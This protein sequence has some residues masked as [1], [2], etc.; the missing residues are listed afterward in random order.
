MRGEH[1]LG[2]DQH[3]CQSCGVRP[4][5]GVARLVTPKDAPL[6]TSIDITVCE[7]CEPTFAY[8]FDD[9][10]ALTHLLSCNRTSAN[11]HPYLFAQLRSVAAPLEPLPGLPQEALDLITLL[12][13]ARDRVPIKTVHR[14]LGHVPRSR[15]RHALD[16]I[17]HHGYGTLGLGGSALLR[18]DYYGRPPLLD[19][20]TPIP[21][22]P[23]LLQTL[24][25]GGELHENVAAHLLATLAR[26][27]GQ[28][29]SRRQFKKQ[30]LLPV[31]PAEMFDS[32]VLF[33]KRL[34]INTGVA[35]H[36][37]DGN[38]RLSRDPLAYTSLQTY[39]LLRELTLTEP[40]KFSRDLRRNAL[41][42]RK[43]VPA[44]RAQRPR[45]PARAKTP[46]GAT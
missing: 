43:P 28:T 44:K 1:T 9:A 33:V 40:G 20:L 24:A 7:L 17:A 10:A 31:L 45:R 25:N 32:R 8:P 19:D 16:L 2:R 12:R 30:L 41:A 29:F 38:I 5:H 27:G 14:R 22:E 35:R 18:Y 42:I 11:E 4:A 3:T 37:Q 6:R 34:L 15:F 21:N 36:L 39:A 23:S 26:N 46:T 13:D